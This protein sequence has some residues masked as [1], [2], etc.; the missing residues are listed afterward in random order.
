[1]KMI[2]SKLLTLVV[3]ALMG[4]VASSCSGKSAGEQKVA[5]ALPD[6]TL[7]KSTSNTEYLITEDPE[8]QSFWNKW[9][10]AIETRNK[11]Q[12]SELINFPLMNGQHLVGRND[13]RRLTRV[14]LI[15]EFDRFFDPW[16]SEKIVSSSIG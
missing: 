8:I 7:S 3:I 6:S 10:S 4:K 12:V 11:E 13:N 14:E 5:S 15:Q 2:C 1:M 16:V 9:K